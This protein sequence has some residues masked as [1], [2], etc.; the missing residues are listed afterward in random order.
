[1]Y[2]YVFRS[3]SSGNGPVMET[4]THDSSRIHLQMTGS[5]VSD[6]TVLYFF[7]NKIYGTATV[8][9]MILPEG[10]LPYSPEPEVTSYA[11]VRFDTLYEINGN[12]MPRK[13]WSIEDSWAAVVGISS[14]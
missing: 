7:R 4:T 5:G 12:I 11:T 9:K 1:M 3:I 8:D 14:R 13:S 2:D 6:D 10:G